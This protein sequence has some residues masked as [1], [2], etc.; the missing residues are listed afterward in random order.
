MERDPL[1]ATDGPERVS[2]YSFF[3][4]PTQLEVKPVKTDWHTL[5]REMNLAVWGETEADAR[6]K[7]SAAVAKAAELRGR[8]APKLG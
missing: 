2:P 6:S 1:D 5:S 7:F 3:E 8:P 4:K